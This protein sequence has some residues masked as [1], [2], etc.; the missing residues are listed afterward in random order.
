MGRTPRKPEAP[1]FWIIAGPNG[2]GKST[3]YNRTDIEGW[4]GSVW[5]VNP[6]L[7]TDR[8]VEQE[9]LDRNTANGMALDRIEHWLGTSIS[10]HQTV[11][12][13]TVLA[14]PK[15]RKWVRTAKALGFEIRL[16]YVF[17]ASTELQLERIRAR[18]ED[19]G[20][21]VPVEKVASRRERSFKQLAWFCR[22]A[23]R[24]IVFDNSGSKTRLIATKGEDGS[25]T[26]HARLPP[27]LASVLRAR[28]IPFF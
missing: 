5:I 25:L 27:D 13:E 3:S 20:H 7:L 11:G 19:G 17:V 23:D 8:L 16:I 6:D 24:V 26:L 4:G 1:V 22:K 18:V 21:D 15:Y 9:G 12:V 28:R 14:S 10:V 2:S